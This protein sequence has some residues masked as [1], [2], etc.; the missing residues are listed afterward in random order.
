MPDLASTLNESPEGSRNMGTSSLYVQHPGSAR[1]GDQC[2]IPGT[3]LTP[4]ALSDVVSSV[5]DQLQKPHTKADLV[6][7]LMEQY[8]P[9]LS[10]A[11]API[12]SLLQAMIEGGLVVEIPPGFALPAE[13]YSS[14]RHLLWEADQRL[15]AG[16]WSAAETLCRKAGK[17][18]AFA[19]VA[20]LDAL[21]ARYRGGQLEG[22]VERACMLSSQLTPPAQVS[23]DALALLAA[24][25]TNDLATAKLI[26]LHLAR[27]FESPW[28]L[29]TVPAFAAL[30]RGQAVVSESNSVEPMLEVIE[31]LL[32]A[33]VG[34]P[35]ECAL[36][37]ALAKR[38]RE[39]R[40]KSGG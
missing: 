33:R 3:P 19:A 27:R 8:G 24:H 9:D 17:H 31:D 22:M 2:I 1:L 6:S 35:G 12:E 36:L 5:Y 32:A 28:D 37:E 13:G 40:S 16:D 18:P 21:I 20:E 7:V 34:S 25:R 14:A 23:C 26:A 4:K 29:P 30:V 15:R 11:T 39:R 10:E 38:Y